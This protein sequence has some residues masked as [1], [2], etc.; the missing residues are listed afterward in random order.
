M[1]SVE[2]QDDEEMEDDVQSE[3]SEEFEAQVDKKKL[4]LRMLEQE[5]G[6]NTKQTFQ[7]EEDENGGL[8]QGAPAKDKLALSFSSALVSR[9]PLTLA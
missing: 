8:V 6:G 3:N 2:E 9:H 5:K 1:K 7:F 4:L